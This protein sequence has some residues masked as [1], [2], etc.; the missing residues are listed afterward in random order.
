[1]VFIFMWNS[2]HARCLSCSVCIKIFIYLLFIVVCHQLWWSG[3]AVE[4][5][6]FSCYMACGILVPWPV[7]PTLQDG[8]LTIKPPGKSLV[9]CFWNS[10]LKYILH[11]EKC[12]YHKRTCMSSYEVNTLD[13]VITHPSP[14]YNHWILAS[15]FCLILYSA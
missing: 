13:Y 2:F 3:S 15:S 5:D 9:H 11:G 14:K 8:L 6:G 12:S 10:W 1:M 4:A 7:F